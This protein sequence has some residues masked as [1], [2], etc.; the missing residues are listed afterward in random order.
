MY[1]T[2]AYLLKDTGDGWVVALF[3]WEDLIKIQRDFFLKL[4]KKYSYCL[5]YFVNVC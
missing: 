5:Y 3:M 1:F 2:K 4:I